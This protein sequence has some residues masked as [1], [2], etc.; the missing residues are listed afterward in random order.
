MALLPE[1]PTEETPSQ[2]CCHCE[3]GIMTPLVT[4]CIFAFTLAFYVP[5]KNPGNSHSTNSSSTPMPLTNSHDFE[6]LHITGETHNA[7]NS[8]DMD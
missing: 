7:T 6:K 4:F 1:T 3:P 2:N 5:F 8:S